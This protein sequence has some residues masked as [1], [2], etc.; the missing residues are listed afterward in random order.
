MIVATDTARAVTEERQRCGCFNR[1]WP[2]TASLITIT[3]GGPSREP[4]RR[5]PVDPACRCPRTRTDAAGDFGERPCGLVDREVE[6]PWNGWTQVRGEVALAGIAFAR[7]VEQLTSQRPREA[8]ARP[9]IRVA[10]EELPARAPLRPLVPPRTT[11]ERGWRGHAG[12]P[13]RAPLPTDRPVIAETY[14][15]YILIIVN[16][17]KRTTP[18]LKRK[19][20]RVN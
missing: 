7:A 8:V 6:V 3:T 2:S 1:G 11:R 4:E 16:G 17:I 13:S 15:N 14:S 10:E 9:V 12:R 5:R 20:T 19:S 18:P